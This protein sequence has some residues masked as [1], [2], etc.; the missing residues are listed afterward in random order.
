MKFTATKS[1]LLRAVT[2]ASEGISAKSPMPALSCVLVKVDE[3]VSLLG[4]NLD[5]STVAKCDADVEQKGSLGLSAARFSHF[6]KTAPAEHITVEQVSDTRIRL[7][8]G[9]AKADIGFIDAEEFPREQPIKGVTFTIPAE[10]LGKHLA[11]VRKFASVD[12]TRFVLNGVLFQWGD[13]LLRLVATD[14]RR[15]A[16]SSFACEGNGQYIV[17][18][19]LVECLA[20]ALNRSD[21]DIRCA[22][23]ENHAL[24]E[25]NDWS[26]YGQLV[27]GQYPNWRQVFPSFEKWASVNTEAFRSILQ[28]AAGYTTERACSVGLEF[29][30]DTLT[31]MAGDNESRFEDSIP[32]KSDMAVKIGMNPHYLLDSLAGVSG[33]EVKIGLID[34]LSPMLIMEGEYQAIT[35]PMRYS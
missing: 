9:N 22:F 7:C 30:H 21:G 10:T 2:F 33:D 12:T 4:T 13:E 23:S 31:V 15:L 6:V 26:V 27:D 32:I 19:G 24:F 35:M 16:T 11:L 5:L 28:R 34:E 18:N 29:T 20:S 17:P 1:N 3:A 25:S 8:S 14:G